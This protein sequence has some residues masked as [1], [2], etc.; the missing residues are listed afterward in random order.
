MHTTNPSIDPY[1]C[2]ACTAI[3]TYQRRLVKHNLHANPSVCVLIRPCAKPDITVS[4]IAPCRFQRIQPSQATSCI[5]TPSRAMS[6]YSCGAM[7][8]LTAPCRYATMCIC[9]LRLSMHSAQLYPY[10]GPCRHAHIWPHGHIHNVNIY[11]CIHTAIVY[12]YIHI[13]P[14]CG[15]K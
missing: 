7:P 14:Y 6:V 9:Q 12:I 11:M 4:R 10:M 13:Y 3:I 8:T 1:T 5:H 2:F 15:E